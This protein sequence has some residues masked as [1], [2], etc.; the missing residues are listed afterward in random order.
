MALLV[1]Y[2]VLIFIGSVSTARS[3]LEKLWPYGRPFGD[4]VMDKTTVSRF[5]GSPKN[6]V[7]KL[8]ENIKW[9]DGR[10]ISK[11]KV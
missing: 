9:F 8:K 10:D 3:P 1:A 4:R 2:T 11:I 7:F 5:R 6:V